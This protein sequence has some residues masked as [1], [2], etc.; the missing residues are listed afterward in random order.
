MYVREIRQ[1]PLICVYGQSNKSVSLKGVFKNPSSQSL[2]QEKQKKIINKTI[3]HAIYN[4][5]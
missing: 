3:D 2:I 5:G 1:T 4:E